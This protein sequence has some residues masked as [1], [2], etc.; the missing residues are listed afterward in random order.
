[1]AEDQSVALLRQAAVT[2]ESLLQVLRLERGRWAQRVQ[3]PAAGCA[4]ALADGNRNNPTR[5]TKGKMESRGWRAGVGEQGL[6]S[7]WVC[8]AW[9]AGP[10][11]EVV[12]FASDFPLPVRSFRYSSCFTD[13]VT[14]AQGPSRS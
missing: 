7:W 6:E 12:P 3:A 14:E 10:S 4:P 5:R 11:Q 13:G 9:E 1:M 2:W 8:L